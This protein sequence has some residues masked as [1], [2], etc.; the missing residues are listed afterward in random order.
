MLQAMSG[1]N[2]LCVGESGGLPQAKAH[3]VDVIIKAILAG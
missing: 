1:F 2:S 3:K